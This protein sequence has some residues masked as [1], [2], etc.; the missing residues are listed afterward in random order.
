MHKHLVIGNDQH[1]S[2]WRNKLLGNTPLE[3]AY[4]NIFQLTNEPD[5]TIHQHRD[6][7]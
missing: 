6:G 7:T 5:T 1:I 3:V 4:P 2:F